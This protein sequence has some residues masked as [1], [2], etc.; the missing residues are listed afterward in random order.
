MST[1]IPI[2]M[3][4]SAPPPAHPSDL[5]HVKFQTPDKHM[6]SVPQTSKGPSLKQPSTAPAD[7]FAHTPQ[8]LKISVKQAINNKS[9]IPEGLNIKDRIFKMELM[10]PRTYATLHHAKPLLQS[11]STEGCPVNCGPTWSTEKIEAAVIQ[12][13]HMS[14]KSIEARTA[15]RLEAHT[16]V[17]N[18][19][20]KIL[21]YKTI[22]DRLPPTLKVSPTSCILHKSRQYCVILDLSFRLRLNDK[23]LSLVNYATV[24][25]APQESMG[26]LGSTLKRLVAVMVD[27]YNLDFPFFFTK[28]N[29]SDGCWRL[30]VSH[31]QVCNFYYVLPATDGQ[32]VSLGKTKTVVPTALQMGWCESPP[33]FCV[34]S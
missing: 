13:P 16:K 7:S 3:E 1:S 4:L 11:F 30:V 29:I 15:L 27:N 20:A 34:G 10:W 24:K 9:S 21:K 14:S 19:F 5:Q 26:Q 23:Y 32:Q 28:L 6:T 25:T 8:H 12:R 22:K 2:F 31:L 18:G 17:N 33:F